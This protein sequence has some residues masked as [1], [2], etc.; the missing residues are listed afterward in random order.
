MGPEDL[1]RLQIILDVDTHIGAAIFTE[2]DEL[3]ASGRTVVLAV[4][5][6]TN[7]SLD[8]PVTT[9]FGL[10]QDALEGMTGALLSTIAVAYGTETAHHLVRT[11]Q[12]FLA[13]RGEGVSPSD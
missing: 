10:S 9:M 4:T 12:A 11:V 7:Q 8:E 13:Q 6:R 5:H 2:G 3:M 1:A